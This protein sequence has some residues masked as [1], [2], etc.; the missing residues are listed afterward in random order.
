MIFIDFL[1]ALIIALLFTSIIVHGFRW[2]RSGSTTSGSAFIFA[3]IWILLLTWF[4]GV[5]VR[6]FGPVLW[7]GYWLPF[8]I[9]GFFFTA[10]F[11]ALLTP[12]KADKKEGEK[13]SGTA[14]TTLGGFFWF[15]LFLI[16]IG[17]IIHYS[18]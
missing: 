8:L 10:L 1:F 7:G 4:G 11:L 18:A 12:Y 2:R 3:F 15:I 17:L 5:W 16:I 9:V 6:P 13:V 14:G